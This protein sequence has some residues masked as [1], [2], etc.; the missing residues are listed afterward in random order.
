M[1]PHRY[2]IL[3]VDRVVEMEAR[4]RIVALKNVTINEPY[5]IGHF[6]GRPVV[7]GVLLI[8]GIAQAGGLLLFNEVPDRENKL[9]Y[10]AAIDEARFRRPVVPGDQIRYELEVLK[11]RSAYCKLVGKVVVDG[12]VAAEAVLTSV[13]VDR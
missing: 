13:M 10:F 3:L 9:L 8:E 1:L 5:F 7:P 12:E 2:P 11:L 4:K 6:P